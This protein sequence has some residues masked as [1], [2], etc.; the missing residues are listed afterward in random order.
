MPEPDV[1][2]APMKWEIPCGSGT[3]HLGSRTQI[4]GILNVTPD[5]FSDGGQYFSVDRAVRRALEMLEE[6]A[7]I[8]D[9]GGESTRPGSQPID[10]DEELRRVLP[11]IERVRRLAPRAIIS[12]DTYKAD[13]AEAALRAGAHIIN[14]V[15]GFL[16]D[17]RMAEVAARHRVPTVLMH[18]QIGT[19]YDDLI[20]DIIRSLRQSLG[21]AIAAGL[22]LEMTIIDPG[23]GFGKTPL[24]NLDL[25]RDLARLR[26]LGRPILLGT[27][28]KSTIGKVLGG[29][30]P[31]E[32]VEGTAATVALGIAFGADIVRVHD[33]R[34]MKRVGMMTDAIVRPDRGGFT[35][36]S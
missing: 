5:S 35:G 10:S 28:R 12:V 6:G 3:L 20:A 24:Q 2:P 23:V 11:V 31:E 14:D 19:R 15:W 27:S 21:I 7:D 29:L 8:L 18:N 33:V 25:L 34:Y 26:V 22:P 36:D 17:P 30:P 9:V 1:N 32:R 16:K 13:V 4:M